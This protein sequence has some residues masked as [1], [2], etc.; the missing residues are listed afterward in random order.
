[1]QLKIVY[2][3]VAMNAAFQ[4]LQQTSTC[5]GGQFNSLTPEAHKKISQKV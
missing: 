4:A 1:M 3:Y 2:N 5:K